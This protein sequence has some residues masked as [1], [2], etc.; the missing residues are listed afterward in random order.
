M[1]HPAWI[2]VGWKGWDWWRALSGTGHWDHGMM[3]DGV[4]NLQRLLTSV[5]VC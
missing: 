4:I 2:W 1:G 5:T 3:S